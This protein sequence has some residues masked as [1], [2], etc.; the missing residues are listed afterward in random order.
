MEGRCDK[1]EAWGKHNTIVSGGA[2]ELMEVKTNIK[3]LS[4][5]ISYFLSGIVER[6]TLLERHPRPTPSAECPSGGAAQIIKA[7]PLD[8]RLVPP[9]WCSLLGGYFLEERCFVV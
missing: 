3:L 5:L 2:L 8:R 9:W 4:L 6:T 7:V 1:W